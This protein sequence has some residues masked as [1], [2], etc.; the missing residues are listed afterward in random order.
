[1][2]LLTDEQERELVELRTAVKERQRDY[3]ET[4]A[5]IEAATGI[6]A[7]VIKRYVAAVA[8]DKIKQARLEAG[9]LVLLFDAD[10][11]PLGEAA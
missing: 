2:R 11:L 6:A 4:V 8:D 3:A 10:V 1:M 5:T 9:Q 7:G